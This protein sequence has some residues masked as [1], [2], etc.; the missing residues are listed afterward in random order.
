MQRVEPDIDDLEIEIEDS[1]HLSNEF[2]LDDSSDVEIEIEQVEPT[3][4]YP[5]DLDSRNYLEP[6][7]DKDNGNVKIIKSGKSKLLVDN[8]ESLSSEEYN[9][10]LNEALSITGNR[11]TTSLKEI[12]DTLNFND[13][14]SRTNQLEILLRAS[15]KIGGNVGDDIIH[16]IYR[17]RNA[18]AKDLFNRINPNSTNE[19]EFLIFEK[20]F[21]QI[22]E[23]LRSSQEKELNISEINKKSSQILLMK[24]VDISLIDRIYSKSKPFMFV[25]KF[26]T[27]NGLVS[28][29]KCESCSNDD[30]EHKEVL[31]S[32]ISMI[33]IAGNDF[34]IILPLECKRC[35][36]FHLLDKAVIKDIVNGSK[37]ITRNLLTT[38]GNSKNSG[39]RSVMNIAIYSPNYEEITKLLSKYNMEVLDVDDEIE[40]D[41]ENGP[42]EES[43]ISSNLNVKSI[44]DDWENIKKRF[45]ST[46]KLIGDSKFKLYSSPSNVVNP[47][48]V[49]PSIADPSINTDIAT[50]IATDIDSDIELDINNVEPSI[51]S[52]VPNNPSTSANGS[53]FSNGSS[54]D[55]NAIT[56]D[57]DLAKNIIK[58][59]DE[60]F[61]DRHLENVTKIFSTM[62]GNYSY[63]KNMAVASAIN[64]L[65]PLGLNRFS[66]TSKSFYKVYSLFNNLETLGKKELEFLSNEL[67]FKIYDNEGNLDKSISDALFEDINLMN[68]NFELEK[69]KF[70]KSL[71]DNL[72]FLSYMPISSDKIADEDINDYL[73]DEDIKKLLDRVSDLIMLNYIA[74]DWLSRFNPAFKNSSEEKMTINSKRTVTNAL[75]SMRSVNRR[76]SMWELLCRISDLITPNIESILKF[77]DTNDSLNYLCQFLEACHKKDL[78]DMY[79]CYSKIDGNFLNP[80]IRELKDLFQLISL[81]PNK[82]ID[83]DKFSF[84]FP[85]LECDNKFKPKFVRLFEKKGFLPRKLEGSNEEEKLNYY[86]SLESCDDVVNYIPKDVSDLL[87][88]FSDTIKFGRFISYSGLYKDFGVYYGARD[89]LYSIINGKTPIDN[90]LSSLNLS[91]ELA[92]LL[93]EDDYKF[94]K[95]DELIV[96]Y[97]DLV[98]LP[99]DDSLDVPNGTI[100]EKIMF[101]LDN[102]DD[103]KPLFKEF[104]KVYDLVLSIIGEE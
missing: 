22:K 99:L 91:P 74:E 69:S 26:Y 53:V 63:L 73:Y 80:S 52:Y 75:N 13:N 39:Y 83:S 33:N 6:I 32:F 103:V 29:F 23:V 27:S 81:F 25:R 9:Q 88:A 24:I 55:S 5:S 72:Y 64:L 34:S 96:K 92:S 8:L 58:F 76:K 40:I 2:Y 49:N 101:L 45:Y 71:Y 10:V 56:S 21:N 4:F 1:N 77:I 44:D 50:G 18:N 57:S 30:S 61:D 82:N 41:L 31:P 48:T 7:V 14:I 62:H 3:S 17:N 78:Y 36:T 102:Y 67:G 84:Y 19:A 51:N 95:V 98:N 86:E 94:P 104:P 100:K 89:I 15:D 28:H 60:R 16:E 97:I 93:I 66:L 37:K 20:E 68:K 65:K 59:L 90:L 38:T 42:V 46:I 47:S 54:S 87:T 85:N 43:V 79:R 70:I 12:Q 35:G 11:I